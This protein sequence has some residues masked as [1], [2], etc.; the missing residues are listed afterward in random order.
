MSLN[1][2]ITEYIP[3]DGNPDPLSLLDISEKIGSDFKTRSL[4]LQELYDIIS[5]SISDVVTFQNNSGVLIEKGS[6]VYLDGESS[7]IASVVKVD[8]SYNTD[9]KIFVAKENVLNGASGSFIYY[10]LI[11]EIDTSLFTLGSKLYWNVSTGIIEETEGSDKVFVGICVVSNV[12]GSIYFAPQREK[13][14]AFY[15]FNSVIDAGDNKTS[16]IVRSGRIWIEEDSENKAV[17]QKNGLNVLGNGGTFIGLSTASDTSFPKIETKRW[18]G[19]YLTPSHLLNGDLLGLIYFKAGLI[20]DFGADIRA[21]ATQNHTDSNGG[22]SLEFFNT[23]NNSATKVLSLRIDQDGSVSFR[24]YNFPA[25]DG[26][27]N[28][29]LKTDGEGNLSWANGGGGVTSSGTNNY[30]SKFNTDGQNLVNSLLTDNGTTLELI[31]SS[32]DNYKGLFLIKN[33]VNNP[34]NNSFLIGLKLD[35]RFIGNPATTLRIRGIELVTTNLIG[36]YSNIGIRNGV[37]GNYELG[38]NHLKGISNY[39][40]NNITNDEQTFGIFNQVGNPTGNTN[41]SVDAIGIYSRVMPNIG[42]GGTYLAQFRD[43]TEGVGKFIKSITAEGKAN[44]SNINERDVQV[45]TVTGATFT[46]STFDFLCE[47]YLISEYTADTLNVTV[48]FNNPQEGQTYSMVFIQ[49]ASL[50]NLTLPTGYW[51]NDIAPFDFSTELASTERAMITATYLNSTWYF[52][53]KKLKLV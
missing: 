15:L 14:T 1:E 9:S 10:G 36:G 22:T 46:G 41:S 4:T 33:E 8:S 12:S 52:A 26:A 3:S 43:G 44:W 16:D 2:K 30:L 39:V 5:L 38:G 34:T 45:R 18:R 47:N 48:T 17:L 11:D 21:K 28:Q 24:N 42:G 40:G 19:T 32:T 25:N 27:V 29:I 37:N 13:G 31:G 53:V 6:L 51:L 35:N 23:P 20:S 49:S 7:G 50:I